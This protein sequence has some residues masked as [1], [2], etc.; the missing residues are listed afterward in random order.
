MRA[1]EEIIFNNV[2]FFKIVYIS[3]KYRIWFFFVFFED[4][5]KVIWELGWI[6]FG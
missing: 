2:F 4:E 3:K 1:V 6:C 5:R